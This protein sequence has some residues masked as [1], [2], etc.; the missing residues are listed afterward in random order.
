ME[1]VG[2]LESFCNDCEYINIVSDI[3]EDK[4]FMTIKKYK[5]HG[6]TRF[7]HSMRVSYYSYL[8]AKVLGFNYKDT[9]RGGLLHDFFGNDQFDDKK[10]FYIE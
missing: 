3:L 4:K 2:N 9:A 5:H 7:E 6:I 1:R 8:I 10:V